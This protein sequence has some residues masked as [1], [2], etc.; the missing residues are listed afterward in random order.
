[1]HRH[2]A[3]SHRF[4]VRVYYEDTDAAGVVYYANYLKFCERARTEWLRALGFEQQMLREERG[5]VFVV[6]NVEAEY[7]KSGVLDDA[8]TVETYVAEMGRSKIVFAQTVMRGSERLFES[9]VSVVCVD[10]NK[11]K[12]TSV[13]PDIRTQMASNLDSH[14]ES[15]R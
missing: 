11:R 4:A 3:P 7:L 15:H 6:R 5:L 9:R 14:S 12:P 13:P 1:M 8:L 2:H 10:W